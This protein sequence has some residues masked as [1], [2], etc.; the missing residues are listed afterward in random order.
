[1]N[2]PLARPGY[3]WAFNYL[4]GERREIRDGTSVPDGFSVRPMMMMMD[5]TQSF[6]KETHV[7]YGYTEESTITKRDR[8]P[9]VRQTV[10]QVLGDAEYARMEAEG[11][12]SPVRAAVA[13]FWGRDA[14]RTEAQELALFDAIKPLLA[15]GILNMVNSSHQDAAVVDRRNGGKGWDAYDETFDARSRAYEERKI[16]DANAWKNPR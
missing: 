3:F 9:V 8:D 10:R 14:S 15:T 1:M 2:H 6:P 11:G 16:R 12:R 4:T 13:A 7:S 5:S